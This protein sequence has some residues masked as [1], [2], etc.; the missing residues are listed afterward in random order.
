MVYT[1][2]LLDTIVGPKPSNDLTDV[3]EVD[4]KFINILQCRYT[5]PSTFYFLYIA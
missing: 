3:A 2:I 5:I 4:K 1:E